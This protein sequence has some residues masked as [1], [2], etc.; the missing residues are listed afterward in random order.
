MKWLPNWPGSYGQRFLKYRDRLFTFL[1][2][3]GV[4]W[5]NNNAEHAIKHFAKYRRLTNGQVTANGLQPYLVLLSIYQTCVY[6]KV[7]FLDF[8]LSGEK[9]VDAF[10]EARRKRRR[11]GV[12][13]PNSKPAAGVAGTQAG[14][15][16]GREDLPR[17]AGAWAG[18]APRPGEPA[19]GLGVGLGPRH[20]S[21]HLRAGGP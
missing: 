13:R 1:D 3:D 10:V 19:E 4:P 18:V 8:L 6:K 12:P 7:S 17:Q 16:A 21:A 11:P 9:D 15:G 2:Y 5:H 20:R 14:P